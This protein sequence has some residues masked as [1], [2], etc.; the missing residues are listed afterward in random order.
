MKL[1]TNSGF[2][3]IIIVDTKVYGRCLILDGELQSA[4]N[5]EW[6]YHEALVHPAMVS[7]RYANEILIMGGGEGST[8]RECLKHKSVKHVVMVDLDKTVTDFCK[9]HL[10]NKESFDDDRVEVVNDDAKTHVENSTD[11]YDMVISDLPSPAEGGPSK[12]LYTQEFFLTIKNRLKDNGFFVLQAANGSLLNMSL[13]QRIKIDLM[14]VFKMVEP[15]YAYVPSFQVPW[16]FLMASDD[17]RGNPCFVNKVTIKNY[18]QK[19]MAGK[20]KFYDE[21][22]HT[23]LFHLPKYYRVS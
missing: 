23:H 16:G 9:I 14:K 20:L 3:D 6:I 17:V 4:S 12:E 15:Y 5:D 2:Q 10:G 8:L 11:N 13:H 19:K 21:I 18:I 22:T 7:H 1:R